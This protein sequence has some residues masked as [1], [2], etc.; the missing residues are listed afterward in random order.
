MPPSQSGPLTDIATVRARARKHIHDGAVTAGYTADR[1]TVLD[2]LNHALATELVCNLRYRYHHFMA[3]GIHAHAIASEFLE[4]AQEEQAHADRI[5][6]RIVQLGGKPDFSPTGL[7]DRSHAEYVEGDNLVQMIEE[8]L[9]AERIAV[10]TYREMIRYFGTS[11]PTSRRLIEEIL[12]VEEEHAEELSTL[13]DVLG[14]KGEPSR[15][16]LREATL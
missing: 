15:D 14:A 7:A 4:H 16:A 2:L 3:S 6:A 11:D 12:A 13:F 9:I 1:R 5:A 8:D 10:D